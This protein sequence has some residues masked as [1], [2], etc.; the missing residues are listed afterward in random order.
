MKPTGGVG[1]GADTVD[2]DAAQA[3]ELRSARAICSG[4]VERA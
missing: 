1:V 2:E 4:W 3:G